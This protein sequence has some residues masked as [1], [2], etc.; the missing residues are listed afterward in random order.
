MSTSDATCPRCHELARPEIVSAVEEGSPLADR[1]L[2]KL[3]IPPSDIVRVDGNADSAF[4]RL[5]DGH[6]GWIAA[7]RWR[8][9]DG[10]PI[11]VPST[12]LLHFPA[13]AR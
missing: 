5:A 9:I 7:S 10:D 11:V 4:L 2:A 12:G 3:G 6:T 1:P 8:A 13:R